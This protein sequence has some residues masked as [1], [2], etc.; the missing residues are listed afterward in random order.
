M[1]QR[2]ARCEAGQAPRTLGCDAA[3]RGP[4]P[5][6]LLL[7]G[8]TNSKE[9]QSRRAEGLAQSITIESGTWQ[10]RGKRCLWPMADVVARGGIGRLR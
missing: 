10:V 8:S 2:Q 7:C 6:P 9:E 3:R 5:A 1:R 4:R